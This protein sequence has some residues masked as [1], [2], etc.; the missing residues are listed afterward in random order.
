VV[1]TLALLSHAQLAEGD[2]PGASEGVAEAVRLAAGIDNGPVRAMV[3]QAAGDLARTRGDLELAAS[4]Y[5]R[6]LAYGPE[7]FEKAR[8]LDRLAA[9]LLGSAP[10]R[11]AALATLAA[12]IRRRN[13]FAVPPVDAPLLVTLRDDQW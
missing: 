9:A 4:Q 3:C 11:A 12:R 10:N 7:P 2:V 1:F 8:L 5:T 13:G 6:G